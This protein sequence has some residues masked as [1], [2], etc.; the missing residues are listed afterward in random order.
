[1]LSPKFCSPI[2]GVSK[3]MAHEMICSQFRTSTLAMLWD[4]G[5]QYTFDPK[6]SK[7]HRVTEDKE[8]TVAMIDYFY[9][10][11]DPRRKHMF[12]V[13]GLVNGE[14]CHSALLYI[15]SIQPCRR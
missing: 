5:L 14:W 7:G 15:L 4:P 8:L 12:W 13:D 9:A 2:F 10:K 6:A 1:M 11:S 3:V